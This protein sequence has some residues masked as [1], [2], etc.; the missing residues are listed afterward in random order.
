M[1]DVAKHR[2]FSLVA[3]KQTQTAGTR[4]AVSL[5]GRCLLIP[6]SRLL[7]GHA[8][9]SVQC[10]FLTNMVQQNRTYSTTLSALTRS[11]F[12]TVRPSAFAVLRLISKLNLVGCCTGK[13]VGLF[14]F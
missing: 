14:P 13:S 10:Q 12:G 1:L 4:P 8:I 9:S 2:H 6:S 7:R 11:V 5:F 3:A